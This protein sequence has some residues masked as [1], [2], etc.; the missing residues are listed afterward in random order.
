M[1][2]FEILVLSFLFWI[3]LTLEDLVPREGREAKGAWRLLCMLGF[4]ACLTVALADR[5]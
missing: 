4:A 5:S 1:S 2:A 3:Q